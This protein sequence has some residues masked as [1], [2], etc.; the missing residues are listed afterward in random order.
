MKRLS[1]IREPSADTGT[2]GR[3]VFE[4]SIW[5]SLELPDRGN[6]TDV[7]C[8]PPG[9]YTASLVFS[10]HFSRNIYRLNN[11][12]GRV[13]V[14]IHPANWAGDTSKG[15]YSD[16]EGC[17]TLGSHTADLI[18]PGKTVPQ[19]A[20]TSSTV[21]VDQFMALANGEDIEVEIR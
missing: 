9:L 10:Q 3:A 18:P 16:L 21:C 19:P 4:G 8:I 5:F 15:W 2:F 17:I 13:G 20:V 11:V 1:I 12:P 14:E 7:S 6:Q